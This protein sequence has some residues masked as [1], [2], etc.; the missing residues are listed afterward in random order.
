[1]L[2][3]PASSNT[4]REIGPEPQGR[5][6]PRISTRAG[7]DG[8]KIGILWIMLYFREYYLVGYIQRATIYIRGPTTTF[9]N[10]KHFSRIYW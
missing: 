2:P 8:P 4:R 6:L 1:M 9:K 3:L 7:S 5:P 10:C